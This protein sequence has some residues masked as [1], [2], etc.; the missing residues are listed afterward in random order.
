MM[1]RMLKSLAGWLLLIS[2]CLLIISLVGCAGVLNPKGVIANHERRLFYDTLALMLIVVLPVIV[3]SLSFVYHYQASHR[4]KDYKP[5][6]SHSLFLET[7]WWGIPCLIIVVLAILT[8]KK[9]YELDPF[10]T[11]VVPDQTNQTIQAIALPWKW[12]F[13]YPQQGIATINYLVLAAGQ[14][15][16]FFLTTDN[17]P[18]SAFF[19]PQIGSQIYVM[20][21]MRSRINL[22]PTS[23]GDFEG[24]NTQ[25]NG[26]GFSD[27]HFA[28]HVVP[29][30]QIQQWFA[31]IKQSPNQLT[32]VAY[33]DLLKPSI[34]KTPSFFSSVP[35]NLFNDVVMLYMNSFGTAHP[36][37]S[38]G[39]FNYTTTEST[40]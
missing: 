29:P 11:I 18:M 14:P 32:D 28:V 26:A 2:G 10:N 31:Q 37:S 13:I 16:E 7:L 9:T 1:A 34:E 6:W 40:E 30:E 23:P 5:N 21:G 12:L 24:L 36:R 3:M 4:V 15:V 22:L 25:F 19:I 38:L 39:H 27:M 20:A 8:W 33:K 35:P 17:V